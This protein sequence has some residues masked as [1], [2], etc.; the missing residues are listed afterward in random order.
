MMGY[1]AFVV[2]LGKMPEE[3]RVFIG[4][5]CVKGLFQ[6][7]YKLSKKRGRT[8]MVTNVKNTMVTFVFV[9]GVSMYY[10]CNI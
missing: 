10:I 5:G 7:A 4:L 9:F 3:C 8:Q 1:L 6:K 2:P